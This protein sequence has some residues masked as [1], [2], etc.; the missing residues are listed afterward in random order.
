[1]A[2]CNKAFGIKAADLAAA[3]DV[4]G[5]KAHLETALANPALTVGWKTQLTKL[6]AFL[7]DGEPRFSIHAGDGNS[8]LPFVSFSTAPGST[9]PGAGE[10]LS[11][12]YSYRA[13]RY[14]AAMARQIQNTVLMQTATGRAA[15]LADLDKY[16]KRADPVLNYRL[17][18]DG[19]FQNVE[20]L[21]FWMYA[22]AERPWLKCYGYS[23]SWYEFVVY[24]Q[25]GGEFPDNYLLNL[26]SGSNATAEVAAQVRTLSCVRGEFNAVPLGR[27]VLASDHNNREHQAELRQAYG[28]KAFTCPGKCGECTKVEHA[29]GSDRFKGVDIIIA[30]H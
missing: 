11:F 27:N 21:S 10:C 20:Q 7:Q 15:I 1:M 12:C 29:C 13:W 22:L 19:D 9:C 4:G 5:L 6:V 25:A 23:K 2:I 16:A 17:Y 26:S 3:Y 8:K 30:V 18:V 24:D 28:K 14:P